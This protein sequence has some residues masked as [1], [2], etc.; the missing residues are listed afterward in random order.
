[1]P[2]DHLKQNGEIFDGLDIPPSQNDGAALFDELQT[3]KPIEEVLNA[4]EG[5]YA[6]VWY[7]A[8]RNRLYWCRDCL[9]RRS[10]MVSMPTGNDEGLL[11]CSVIP[12]E[13]SSRKWD[14]VPASAVFSLS[15]DSGF[16]RKPSKIN[17][18]YAAKEGC[19]QGVIYYPFEPINSSIPEPP[20]IPNRGEAS[21]PSGLIF[22][23]AFGS[24][25]LGFREELSE[26]VRKRVADVPRLRG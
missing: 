19:T 3:G 2:A 8:V 21:G 20:D 12:G 26:A 17:R 4:M 15:L 13:L 23:D 6:F 22:N 10:L 9:G 24:A 14:E 25:L 18:S 5:P 1:M 11:L 7:D 16:A